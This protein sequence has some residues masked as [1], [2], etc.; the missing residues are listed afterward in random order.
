MTP[1][2][3]SKKQGRKKE[4][5]LH[6]AGDTIPSLLSLDWIPPMKW[7]PSNMDSHLF[8]TKVCQNALEF[9]CL[10]VPGAGWEEDVANI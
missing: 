9:V 3:N 5:E 1:E 2:L 8:T 10:C 7:S 6:V 4:S